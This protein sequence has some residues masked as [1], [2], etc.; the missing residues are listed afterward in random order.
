MTP[1]AAGRRL[2]DLGGGCHAWLRPPGC[3]G[4][5]N[6]GLIVNGGQGLVV[7]TQNDMPMARALHS[8]IQSMPHAPGV[9]M[10]VNTHGDG[11]HWNG[12]LLF[13]GATIIA[14]EA[15]LEDIRGHWLDPSKIDAYA[16]GDT[17]FAEFMRWRRDVF[18]YEGWRPVHPN[19]TYTEQLRLDVGNIQVELHEFGPA[20]TSGDTIVWVPDAGVLYSGDLV[21]T[22]ST[23]IMWGGP[24]SRCVEACDRILALEPHTIVPGHGPIIGPEGIAPI[25]DYLTFVIEY[26]KTAYQQGK[27]PR[28]AY[29]ELDLTPWRSWPHLSRT[30]QN[31]NLI[32]RE[33]DPQNFKGDVRDTLNVVYGEDRGDW[34]G[35]P[36]TS[37]G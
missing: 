31:I 34:R 18:N 24:L 11:D 8:A 1:G 22:A 33:L 6:S 12:N 19:Q 35:L 3:W 28:E 10:V 14:S 21:F 20:H 2:Q 37:A 23:P 9:D 29:D 26:A 27:S 5:A 13:D 36:A 16:Q 25:R 17:A 4:F 7:D 15:T 32:Y 30:Y